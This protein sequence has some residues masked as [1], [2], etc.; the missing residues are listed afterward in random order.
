MGVVGL[1]R[2]QLFYSVNIPLIQ[3]GYMSLCHVLYHHMNLADGYSL[4][5]EVHQESELYI[6]DIVVPD[7][8]EA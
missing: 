2:Q 8:P 1:D 3:I 5:V 6:V 7:I 4:V